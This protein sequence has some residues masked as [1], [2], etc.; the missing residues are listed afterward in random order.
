MREARELNEPTELYFAQPL[1]VEKN[2]I[3]TCA[4]HLY[5][6]RNLI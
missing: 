4:K 3:A 1:E 5:E 2:A 6:S